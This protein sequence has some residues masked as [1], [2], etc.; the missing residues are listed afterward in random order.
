MEAVLRNA[1]EP[2]GSGKN[3]TKSSMAAAE[4]TAQVNQTKN[5]T[6]AAEVN[7]TANASGSSPKPVAE[8]KTPALNTTKAPPK[9]G[10][11]HALLERADDS[12]T[13][14][15]D[16]FATDV[17]DR[18]ERAWGD[19]ADEV[20]K[21]VHAAE[22][23]KG[24]TGRVV[25]RPVK[26]TRRAADAAAGTSRRTRTDSEGDAEDEESSE[27]RG[28]ASSG[29]LEPVAT[30]TTSRRSTKSPASSPAVTYKKKEPT[31]A[32][33]ADLTGDYD[34]DSEAP[35]ASDKPKAVEE[36]EPATPSP[37]S[38]KPST[39]KVSKKKRKSTEVEEQATS[40][41]SSDPEPSAEAEPS[42]SST[43]EG[44]SQP[45]FAKPDKETA[46]EDEK[47]SKRSSG[48]ATAPEA[49]SEEP[50]E[51]EEQVTK[52]SKKASE[53]ETQETTTSKV[54]PSE[55][56]TSEDDD[57]SSDS[58]RS[59]YSGP[60]PRNKK[61]P[62]GLKGVEKKLYFVA[63]EHS[64]LADDHEIKRIFDKYAYTPSKS[65]SEESSGSESDAAQELTEENAYLA[66]RAV[67]RAWAVEL[68]GAADSR[69]YSQYF[70]PTWKS[71][72]TKRSTVIGADQSVGFMRAFLGAICG[73]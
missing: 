16:D 42:K 53:K 13:G 7:K 60:A 29:T 20:R 61:A 55:E 48:P 70:E 30:R 5:T 10:T 6:D 69:V 2:V 62:S 38:E 40:K 67:L 51:E 72:A 34:G 14:A 66:S 17:D 31:T 24:P 3:A 21:E 4:Q 47:A 19:W 73:D 23:A 9:N 11:A 12:A 28:D 15:A 59:P 33:T 64:T 32:P 41:T 49:T 43:E 1:S 68:D 35:T 57:A 8:V 26:K 18:M 54:D 58:A 45:E 46:T 71:Y 56:A 63:Q 36:A 50:E 27:G 44:A 39:V 25:D 22:K 37:D 65:G 52:V